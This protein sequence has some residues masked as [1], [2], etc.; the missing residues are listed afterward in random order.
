M[1]KKVVVHIAAASALAVVAYF[2]LPGLL[3]KWASDS[4]RKAAGL[5]QKSLCIGD[6]EIA[7]LEGGQGEAIL[8]VHGFAANK[9]N[10]TRFAKFISP[11]Y[12]VVALDLPGFG[13]STCLENESYGIAEQAKRL[14][15]FADAVGLQKF[16]IV[17]NSMGGYIAARYAVMFPE[18]VLS[19]GLFNTAGVQSPVPSE[20]AKLVSKG[21]PNPLVTGSVEEFDRLIQFVFSTPPDIPRFVKKLLVEEAQKHK[22]SNERIFKQISSEHEALEPDLTKIKARTLVLWGDHD[23]VLDV[24]SVQVLKKGLPDC[25]AVIMKDCGHLPMIERPQ[26]AAEHYLTFLKSSK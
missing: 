11:G 4:E 2:V 6:Y 18:R 17:G 16:H 3:M 21:D 8:M 12:R 15:L 22:P 14:N 5:R 19:L 23:R 25:T 7:Y 20:M 1:K 24:S 10:W 26:E 13:D 9:D